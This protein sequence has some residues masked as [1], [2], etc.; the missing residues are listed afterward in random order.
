MLGAGTGR[1]G[2]CLWSYGHL[3]HLESCG[4]GEQRAKEKNIQELQ[5]KER[6]LVQNSTLPQ[7][8]M[9]AVL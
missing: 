6:L 9:V 3:C 4:I 2:W 7:A 8:I 1:G 5:D